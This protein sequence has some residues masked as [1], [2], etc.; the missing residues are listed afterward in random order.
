M[1]RFYQEKY[2]IDG[3]EQD[4]YVTGSDA[5]GLTMGV[6][7]TTQLPIYSY[8]H[9]RGA[10]NYVI[11]DHFFQ[12]RQRRFV[13]QPPVADRRSRARG[14]TRTA[15]VPDPTK[16]PTNS[17]LDSN[18]MPATYPQYTATGPVRDG[19]LTQQCADPADT[20][21]YALACG[22]FAVNTV[23]PSSRPYSANGPFIPLIDDTKY[24][25]IGD[26]L[27]GK[28]IS[29]AWYSGGWD[30]ANSGH[31]GPLFQYHHQPFNYFAAY[32][33]GQPGRAHLQDETTFLSRGQA[34]PAPDGQ[35]R[36]AVRRGE[37][38]PRLRQRDQRK[39]APGRPDQGGRAGAVGAATR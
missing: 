14:S 20:E 37:R 6:Y 18:G 8:L 16:R 24:P 15:T 17:I 30:D 10:P 23:Q 31:P 3:G 39:P 26:R 32:A 11:A 27:S 9:R 7:D 4:R 38:A 29:W 1:H 12:G 25:N 21:N 36:Q 19:Q 35:L 22:D 13:P 2:Q 34:R 28:D 33:P 5:V